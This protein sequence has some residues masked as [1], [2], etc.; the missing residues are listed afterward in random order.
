VLVLRPGAGHLTGQYWP[1]IKINTS[2]T[3]Y[4]L[5]ETMQLQRFDG[6][7]YQPFGGLVGR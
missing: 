3:D 7:S 4:R 1:G 6:T 5:I 2:P